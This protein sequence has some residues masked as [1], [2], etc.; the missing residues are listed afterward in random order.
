MPRVYRPEGKLKKNCY[1]I[2]NENL[3]PIHYAALTKR[4]FEQLG[5]EPILYDWEKQVER[6]RERLPGYKNVKYTGAPLC[7]MFIE[8]WFFGPQFPLFNP[9]TITIPIDP[10]STACG[11]YETEQRFPYLKRKGGRATRVQLF[12]TAQKGFVLENNVVDWFKSKWP[13]IIFDA[14]NK[15]LWAEWCDHDFKIHVPF[16]RT[17]YKMDVQ[18]PNYKD[19]YNAPPRK[20]KADYHIQCRF[21]DDAILIESICTGDQL[22]E[23]DKIIPVQN[24]SPLRLVVWLNCLSNRIDYTTLRR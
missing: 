10:E 3:V 13:G 7:L 15:G 16:S 24:I 9:D 22:K 6:V 20:P 18:G 17:V 21:E 19:E 23:S 5:L 4:A 2:L 12:E 8:H 14:D 11:M 1:Q